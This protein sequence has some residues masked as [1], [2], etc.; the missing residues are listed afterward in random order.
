[1]KKK[2]VVTL[3][4]FLVLALLYG[5]DY[6]RAKTFSIECVEMVPDTGI[7]DGRTP[8][9]MTF[10]LKDRHGDPVEGHVLYAVSKNGGK[11]RSYREKTGE[12]GTVIFDYYPYKYV[13][14]LNEIK[15]VELVI[16]DES[17]SIFFEVPTKGSVTVKIV[18]PDQK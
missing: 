1:M 3:C 18:S 17:N 7:A 15:D 9:T 4:V 10:Q 12:D 5:Y 16:Q 14:G 6:V 2:L 8:V 11:F 13:K